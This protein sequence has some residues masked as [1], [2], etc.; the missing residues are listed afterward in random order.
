VKKVV[1]TGMG[2]WSSIGQNLHE[3]TNNLRLGKSGVRF[4]PERISLGLKSA[5]VGSVPMPDLRP[6]LTVSQRLT[7]SAGAKYAYMAANQALVDADMND[8]Y[9]KKNDVGVIIGDDGSMDG[10]KEV[11]DAVYSY[12]DSI[13]A[14]PGCFFK[15][16]TSSASMNI[17]SLFHLRGI[18]FT[19]GAACAS[20]IHA[21]GIAATLIQCGMQDTILV[22]GCTEPDAMTTVPADALLVL[23]QNHAD[24]S[25]ASRPFDV[26]H[27]GFVPSGGAAMLVLEEY[28]HAVARGAKIYAEVS[29]YG[30]SSNGTDSISTPDVEGEYKAMRRA[31]QSAAVGLDEITYIS[32]HGTSTEVGDRIEAMALAKLLDGRQIP[33][34]ATKSLTG[35]E[36]WMAGASS[37]VYS[38]LMMNGH[39]IAPTINLHNV[40]PEAKG[41]F[42]P[43]QLLEKDHHAVLVNSFGLGG[44]NGSLVLRKL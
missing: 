20:S 22:G 17:S 24:P 38:I 34:G 8:E 26:N 14:G 28:E 41:L 31:L 37:V 43:T 1:V 27:D 12:K 33:V 19:I 32:A 35:H 23:S 13:M 39:F 36:I 4:D 40:I 11:H 6:L 25:A 2:I 9:L 7:M 16:A 21:V 29:G 15:W 18:S 3:V 44:T 10:Q 30:Y 5:L 42:I